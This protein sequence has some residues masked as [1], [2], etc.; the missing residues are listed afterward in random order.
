MFKWITATI[1]L[2]GIAAC[3]KDPGVGGNATITGKV[4]AH[5]YNSSFSVLLSTYYVPDTYVYIV[6][7]EDINYG[8]RIKTNYD[9]EY[10]FEFLYPGDYTIYTYSLDSAAIVNGVPDPPDSAMVQNITITDNRETITL[11]DFVIYQ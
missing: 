6:Y 1:F 10:A 3:T 2:F 11:P 5:H 9:G 8:S 7:G 4:Y